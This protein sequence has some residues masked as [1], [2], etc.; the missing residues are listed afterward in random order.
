MESVD[1]V[2]LWAFMDTHTRIH[3]A[4]T[5]D[6][7]GVRGRRHSVGFYG[8]HFHPGGRQSGFRVSNLYDSVHRGTRTDT[9]EHVPTQ[10]Y[11]QT[12]TKTETYAHAP[13]R[14]LTLSR[15]L[16]LARTLCV[17]SVVTIRTIA[18]S[19]SLIIIRTIALSLS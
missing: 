1:A 16:S 11:T 10:T 14:S 17:L 15:S 9:E 13:A 8:P 6:K 5:R 3:R 12:Y 18:L 19:L 2:V 4:C 7:N